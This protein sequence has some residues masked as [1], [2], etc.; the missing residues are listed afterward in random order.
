MTFCWSFR[1]RIFS[2]N[3][4]KFISRN[5]KVHRFSKKRLFV[6][7]IV[8]LN[9]ISSFWI[10]NRLF[11]PKIVFWT[12]YHQKDDICCKKWYLVQKTIF[13][14]ETIFDP[15]RRSLPRSLPGSNIV[16]LDLKSSFGPNILFLDQISSFWIK[17]RLSGPKI[18]FA[19]NITKK[20]IIAPKE[21]IWRKNDL[22]SKKLYLV[23]K[24][25]WGKDCLLGP[26]M[27][28]KNQWRLDQNRPF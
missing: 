12:K 23:K 22:R 14:P 26:E 27:A 18:F 11:G 6:P 15:T 7:K 8:F 5:A 9:Q 21:D 19:P 4:Q 28:Q 25:F 13:V 10:K 16:D 1:I 3:S 24:G 17:N 2:L 20:T